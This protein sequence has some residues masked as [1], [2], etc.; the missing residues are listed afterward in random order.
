MV[1]EEKELITPTA[2]P[3]AAGKSSNG[4]VNEVVTGTL[5]V[6]ALIV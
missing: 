3:L 2:A 5:T 6:P 4:R 1:V